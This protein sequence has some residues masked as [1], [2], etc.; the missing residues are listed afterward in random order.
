[1]SVRSRASGSPGGHAHKS[2]QDW[3]PASEAVNLSILAIWHEFNTLGPHGEE[4]RAA[5]RLEPW[6]QVRTRG[7]PSRRPRSARAPQD[8]V[9]VV[10]DSQALP[11]GR[12]EIVDALYRIST[13]SPNIHVFL[14]LY[15]KFR[16]GCDI[17]HHVDDL[18]MADVV[19][20]GHEQRIAAL[21]HF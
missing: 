17:A 1:I 11:R 10:K 6:Q 13:S 3:V 21:R 9:G 8:E 12:T 7:H 19:E 16:A 20:A 18:L 14:G 15:G 4:A 2:F 5:R